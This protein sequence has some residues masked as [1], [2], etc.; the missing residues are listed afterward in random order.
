[1]HTPVVNV[2]NNLQCNL[3]AM[4]DVQIFHDPIH[5]MILKGSF[6]KLMQE[7]RCKKFVYISTGKSMCKG[8]QNNVNRQ[9][10]TMA[11]NEQTTMSCLMPKSS[12]RIPGS[13]FSM[14]KSVFSCERQW[15]PGPSRSIGCALH[16]VV[17]LSAIVAHE[18][19][20]GA[21]RDPLVYTCLYWGLL[22]I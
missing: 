8:L 14:R 3:F 13:K 16:L 2:L 4:C 10:Y 19:C 9:F 21:R 22:D 15:H 6:Y 11:V 1:M 12:Q 17:K 20:K 7:I 18:N 5:K